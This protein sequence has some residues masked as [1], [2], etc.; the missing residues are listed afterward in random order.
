MLQ[1]QY[2]TLLNTSIL[3]RETGEE[4]GEVYDLIIDPKTGK[5]EAFWV[6]QGLLPGADKI[7]SINDISEWKLKIYIT[8]EDSIINPN[9]ILK[10]KGIIAEGISIYLQRVKTLSGQKLGKVV[11]I[12]FDPILAQIVQIQVAKNFLGIP[13]AKRLI[14]FL[15]IYEINQDFVVL[16]D[17]YKYT[18]IKVKEVLDLSEAVSN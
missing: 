16:K 6:K 11:D 18:S 8:D 4:V 2:T 17:Y 3:N 1:K 7:L 13:Y 5:I 15:E 14:S 10:V 12:F 9:E